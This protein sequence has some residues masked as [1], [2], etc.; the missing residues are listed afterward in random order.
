MFFENCNWGCTSTLVSKQSKQKKEK[1]NNK[2][3]M[4]QCFVHE[5]TTTARYSSTI[6][7][8]RRVVCCVLG[9]LFFFDSIM[10]ASG[11]VFFFFMRRG[12]PWR[13]VACFEVLRAAHSENLVEMYTPQPSQFHRVSFQKVR[14]YYGPII[15]VLHPR[16][17]S[18]VFIL[19]IVFLY[20][21]CSQLTWLLFGRDRYTW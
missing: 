3:N 20:S 5:K 10:V 1:E 11:A 13:G 6:S 18:G 14:Y 7:S 2:T 8:W 12:W 9:W 19:C 21:T 4:F 16:T 15:I 17:Y